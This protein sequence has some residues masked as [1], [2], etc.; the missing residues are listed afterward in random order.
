VG[1]RSLAELQA[2]L[3]SGT[4]RANLAG[5]SSRQHTSLH[6]AAQSDKPPARTPTLTLRAAW[7]GR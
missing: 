7:R 3:E 1:V 5:D 6:A 4:L 2:A